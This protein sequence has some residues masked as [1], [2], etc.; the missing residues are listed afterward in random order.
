MA[1]LYRSKK[2]LQPASTDPAPACEKR[3]QLEKT[4]STPAATHGAVHSEDKLATKAFPDSDQNEMFLIPGVLEPAGHTGLPKQ[5]LR[6][7]NLT[8][9]AEAL[10]YTLTRASGTLPNNRS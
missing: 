9:K 7:M 1:A 8:V 5:M 3:S 4:P 10:S 2:S 6:T